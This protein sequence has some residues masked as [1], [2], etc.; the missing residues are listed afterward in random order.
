[1]S[2]LCRGMQCSFRGVAWFLGLTICLLGFEGRSDANSPKSKKKVESISDDFHRPMIAYL[3][4]GGRAFRRLRGQKAAILEDAL[5]SHIEVGR[6]IYIKLPLGFGQEQVFLEKM[7]KIISVR[8][9]GIAKMRAEWDAQFQ[10]FKV[11]S[12]MLS[13]IQNNA[14]VY[15]LELNDVRYYKKK[16][17][18]SILS[19]G[20]ALGDAFRMSGTIHLQRFKV[21][22][23]T[24]TNRQKSEDHR[25]ACEGK[26][27]DEFAGF[28]KPY[29][30]VSATSDGS[31]RRGRL[32]AFTAGAQDLGKALFTELAKLPAFQ[33]HTPIQRASFNSV[34]IPLGRKEGLKVGQGFKVFV[35][36][37]RGHL[38][39][40]GYVKVRSVGDNRMKLKGNRRVRV[41]PK[42]PYY[43]RAETIIVSKGLR[44]QKGMLVF[45]NPKNGIFFG[46]S[47]GFVP[48]Q[49]EFFASEKPSLGIGLTDRGTI[50]S[51]TLRLY[52]GYDLTSAWGINELYVD[53]C[54][55][56]SLMD[57]AYDFK[58]IREQMMLSFIGEVGLVK[59]FHFRRLVWLVGLRL[60]VGYATEG[61]SR[62]SLLVGGSAL[63]GLE[64][65][66]SPSLSLMLRGGVRGLIPTGGNFSMIGPW[67]MLGAFYTI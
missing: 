35:R 33:L 28:L 22:D 18:G 38:M 10:G 57:T 17:L 19:R 61:S 66:V 58:T 50:L 32:K 16:L 3:G 56:I 53:A 1:M 48:I 67:A 47:F 34:Y 23:C 26:K 37:M 44:L 65:F 11:T 21:F 51:P 46:G 30:Q 63:T 6:F 31:P 36:H 42:A 29:K 27:N 15:W 2:Q 52:A 8:S 40:R 25:A 59:K 5:R 39:Y 60:G 43:S 13:S 45:E 41:N 55:D 4:I 24:K 7:I 20:V 49:H 12:K 9:K 54:A 14:F 62:S 64:F